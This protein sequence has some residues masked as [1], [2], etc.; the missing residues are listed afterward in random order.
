MGFVHAL[1]P[2]LTS[3]ATVGAFGPTKFP[4]LE[5]AMPERLKYVALPE[6]TSAVNTP[7]SEST[8]NTDM[9]NPFKNKA[10]EVNPLRVNSSLIL[11]AVP[12]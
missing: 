7:A 8:D 9:T 5:T 2:V 12:V 3:A 1:P 11:G 4:T 6:S 10:G